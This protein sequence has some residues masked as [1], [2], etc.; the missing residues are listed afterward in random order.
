[1]PTLEFDGKSIEYRIR[2]SARARRVSIVVGT[3]GT[4]LVVPKGADPYRARAWLKGRAGWIFQKQN[5]LYKRAGMAEDVIRVCSGSQLLYRGSPVTLQLAPDQR[6]TPTLNEA[7]LIV[8]LS[9]TRRTPARLLEAWLRA[10]A[11][12]TIEDSVARYAACL[13]RWPRSV[14]LR[15]QRT[16]WGSCGIRDDLNL[17]WRLVMAPA[18]ALD[19]VALH[20][21]CHLFERN[22]GAAFWSRV[23]RHM[24]EYA[25]HRN[26]LRSQGHRILAP[27]A[28][29]AESG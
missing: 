2:V 18:P 14:R 9:S 20:E 17:N 3:G 26:W 7:V 24:P 23:A 28:D 4:E 19:Y 8:P 27:L 1:M 6:G 25:L 22:H 12:E 21:L 5:E 11:R 16:R 29:E 13:G 15:A 10:R